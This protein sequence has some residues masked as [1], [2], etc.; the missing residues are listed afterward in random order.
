MLRAWQTEINIRYIHRHS[1]II[2]DKQTESICYFL[3]LQINIDDK[4]MVVS[5]HVITQ[6][7]R[8]VQTSHLPK[9]PLKL[10]GGRTQG[11]I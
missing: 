11:H 5:L 7:Q 3:P 6:Y 2:I 9:R 8:R 4:G 1:L 10:E